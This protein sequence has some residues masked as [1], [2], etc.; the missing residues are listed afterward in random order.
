MEN[1]NFFEIR[2]KESN[3]N[4][5]KL[6]N[7]I[8]DKKDKF[9]FQYI[10]LNFDVKYPLSILNDNELKNINEIDRNVDTYFKS[11]NVLIETFKSF[12]NV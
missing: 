10:I 1:E 4:Y 8:K 9:L 11:R 12:F 3:L 6:I 2:K 5:E 7:S